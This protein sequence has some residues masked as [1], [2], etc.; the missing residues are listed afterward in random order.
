MDIRSVGEAERLVTSWI[1]TEYS[2]CWVG[3]TTS[4]AKQRLLTCCRDRAVWGVDMRTPHATSS[5]PQ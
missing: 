4:G 1:I 2:L 5:T 3:A